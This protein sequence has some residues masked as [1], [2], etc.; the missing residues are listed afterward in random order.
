LRLGLN[1]ICELGDFRDDEL[2]GYMSAIYA[3]PGRGPAYAPDREHRKH[4]EAAQAARTFER[5]G[6]LH[7][8]AEILG[9][10]AGIEETTFWLTNRVRRVFATDLYLDAGVWAADAPAQ[11]LTDPG[12]YATCDW[13]P[14]RLV[15]QHMDARDLSYED[16]SFDG[17]Y[18]TSSLEHFGGRA[19]I[20]AALAEIQRVVRPGGVVSLSTEYRLRGDG[21]GI[22]GTRMFDADELARW[23]V[24]P[25][26]WQLV[27]PLDLGV[28]QE[29][30][31]S[32]QAQ[33]AAA[34]GQLCWPHIVLAE[35][36]LAWTSVHLALRVGTKSS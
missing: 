36:D 33:D 2:R 30:L 21:P 16:G 31:A 24:E 22:S 17:V 3:R 28:S 11:M 14:R 5:F 27:E 9:V 26:A 35:G 10:G 29:T 25:F 13:N 15:V 18:C 23:I 4:W 8:D 34:A 20:T 7:P 6:A 32:E 19:E 12:R 1:K